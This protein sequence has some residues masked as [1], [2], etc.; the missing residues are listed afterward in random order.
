MQIIA[1]SFWFQQDKRRC[2]DLFWLT[3]IHVVLKIRQQATFALSQIVLMSPQK[4]GGCKPGDLTF[5]L[6]M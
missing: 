2:C 1:K 6:L 3:I 5:G 4:D